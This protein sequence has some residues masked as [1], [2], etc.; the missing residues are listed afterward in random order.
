VDNPPWKLKG[1]NYEVLCYYMVDHTSSAIQKH[2]RLDDLD[3]PRLMLMERYHRRKSLFSFVLGT[4]ESH[5]GTIVQRS[6]ST[7]NQ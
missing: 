2:D 1:S 5:R 3:V 4:A 7:A 6:L